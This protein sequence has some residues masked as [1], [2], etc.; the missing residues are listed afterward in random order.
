MGNGDS[1]FD[2]FIDFNVDMGAQK[3]GVQPNSRITDI[4]NFEYITNFDS[5]D[6]NYELNTSTDFENTLEV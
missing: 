2:Y 5:Y 3:I 6:K 4:P 1:Y